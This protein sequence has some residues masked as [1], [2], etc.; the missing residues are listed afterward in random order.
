MQHGNSR[1][2]GAVPVQP[3]LNNPICCL[4]RSRHWERT[5]PFHWCQDFSLSCE[6]W[7][8][9][10]PLLLQLLA[11][12]PG[13]LSAELSNCCSQHGAVDCPATGIWDHPAVPALC[14]EQRG[15][16]H[17]MATACCVVQLQPTEVSLQAAAHA[18]GPFCKVLG[19][20]LA[21]G[22]S[23]LPAFFLPFWAI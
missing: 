5:F 6:V 3:P 13:L 2:K 19:S 18:T 14:L 16:G 22:H 15:C 21:S 9:S 8:Q 10:V 7:E 23:W 17:S 12:L 20:A 11:P 1:G 4:S